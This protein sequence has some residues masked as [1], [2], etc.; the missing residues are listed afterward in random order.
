MAKSWR[1][2]HTGMRGG[3]I[4]P[5]SG[6]FVNRK[7]NSPAPES[8][9][10][11]QRH[12]M[13]TSMQDIIAQENLSPEELEAFQEIISMPPDEQLEVMVAQRDSLQ[14]HIEEAP[15][16]GFTADITATQEYKKMLE[17]MNST[18]QM[19]KS[20][21][22]AELQ[23]EIDRAQ[24]MISSSNVGFTAKPFSTSEVKEYVKELEDRMEK[25][26]RLDAPDRGAS[27]W[28]ALFGR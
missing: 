17:S 4:V 25:M 8:V 16:V 23:K 2:N 15:K 22:I 28:E 21:T 26:S 13:A 9:N 18:I 27:P 24:Q 10:E 19:M 6:S 11:E 12:G 14:K 5:I 7:D 1:R 3:K 20:L